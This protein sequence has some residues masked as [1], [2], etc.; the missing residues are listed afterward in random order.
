MEHNGIVVEQKW[1]ENFQWKEMSFNKYL[2]KFKG[3]NN[4]YIINRKESQEQALIG[5][6]MIYSIGK[7]NFKNNITKHSIISYGSVNYRLVS[8]EQIE[9]LLNRYYQK[10]ILEERN[11]EN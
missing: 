7:E 10:W 6:N 8:D 2:I 11:N 1:V 9:N 4:Y 5:A 3:D